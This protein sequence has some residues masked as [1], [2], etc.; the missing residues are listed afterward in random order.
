MD[1]STNRNAEYREVVKSVG[2]V[3]LTNLR[4]A[5]Y[6]LNKAKNW[7]IADILGGGLISTSNKQKHLQAAKV[8]I[9]DAR[10]IMEKHGREYSTIAYH[11]GTDALDVNGGWGVLDYSRHDAYADAVIHDGLEGVI[12]M[13]NNAITQIEDLLAEVH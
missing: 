1:Y 11:L 7:S 10:Y 8:Y 6:E 4:S 3:A 9:S 13:V 12:D 5:L 2:E